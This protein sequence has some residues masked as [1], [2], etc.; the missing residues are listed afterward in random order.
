MASA[1]VNAPC[2]LVN[3]WVILEAVFEPDMVHVL[4]PSSGVLRV[5]P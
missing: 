2:S 4:H 5:G 3:K 1:V